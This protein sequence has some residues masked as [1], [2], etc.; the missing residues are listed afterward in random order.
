MSKSI[1]FSPGP[2]TYTLSDEDVISKAREL[3]QA[4]LPEEATRPSR[5]T[6][7][8]DGQ[9]IRAVWLFREVTGIPVRF[10][11]ADMAKIALE[12]LGFRIL[13]T[14]T[15]SGT[16]PSDDRQH[17]ILDRE[18][19]AIRVFLAGRS[20]TRPTDEKLCDW[21]QF[22]YLFE[23]YREGRDVFAVINPIE[24]NAWHFERTKKLATI[25]KMKAV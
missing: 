23:M 14:R 4:G 2:D 17:A 16:N 21:V 5:T 11:S 9:T 12:Q 19:E 7:A 13:S 25:C 15:A 1:S 3:I 6:L 20:D 18:R 22:C 8:I 24:V 10:L